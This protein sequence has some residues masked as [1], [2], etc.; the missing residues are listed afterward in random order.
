MLGYSG[1]LAKSNGVAG[2]ALTASTTATSLLAANSKWDMISRYFEQYSAGPG[3]QLR[4]TATG[5]IS[6]IITTPG[7]LT[8][9]VRAGSV[10][11]HSSGA[12]PL[13]VLART[14]VH[15][16]YVVDM[17]I[18]TLGSGTTATVGGIGEFTSESIVGGV[19]IAT[20]PPP[21]PYPC[22]STG[23][24]VGTGWDSTTAA[25][26]DLFGTWSLNNANSI[27]CKTF[28]LEQLN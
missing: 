27:Q 24:A 25:T 12:I 13:N 17:E 20:G 22:P 15:W 26:W 19:V 11:V 9:A 2:A 18:V 28:K 1:L 23:Y 14:N 7:T 3:T 10:A 4:L 5:I 8:L 16:K 6:N 21:G